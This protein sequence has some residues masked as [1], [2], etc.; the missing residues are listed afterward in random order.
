MDLV[1]EEGR[2][3]L[4]QLPQQDAVELGQLCD[5]LHAGH[6]GDVE[7]VEADDSEAPYKGVNISQEGVCL[8]LSVLVE[9]WIDSSMYTLAVFKF[10]NNNFLIGTPVLNIGI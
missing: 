1:G 9:G 5:K 8:E 6:Q 7:S 3:H 4:Q 2:L 10:C